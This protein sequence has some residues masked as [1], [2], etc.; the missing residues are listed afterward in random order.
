MTE[1]CA[2][3]LL[4]QAEVVDA[5]GIWSYNQHRYNACYDLLC[6]ILGESNL[7]GTYAYAIMDL[8]DS[9]IEHQKESHEAEQRMIG[10]G[11]PAEDILYLST[12]WYESLRKAKN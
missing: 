7:F 3:A 4:K 11:A 10:K 12:K 1:I 6:R 8:V 5:V 2:E 9:L